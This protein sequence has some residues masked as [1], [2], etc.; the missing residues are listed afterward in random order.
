MCVGLTKKSS[1][2]LRWKDWIINTSWTLRHIFNMLLKQ[3]PI[4]EKRKK[5]HD[6]SFSR[7]FS[8]LSHIFLEVSSKLLWTITQTTFSWKFLVKHF[9]I[10]L[11]KKNRMNFVKSKKIFILDQQKKGWQIVKNQLFYF[12]TVKFLHIYTLMSVS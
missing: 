3:T 7:N 9:K 11:Q 5:N 10:L 1:L 8:K 4:L 2:F 12:K 6:I